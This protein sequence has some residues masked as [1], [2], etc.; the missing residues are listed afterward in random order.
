MALF[1]YLS[2]CCDISRF[3]QRWSELPLIQ[4]FQCLR[5]FLGFRSTYRMLL[6]KHV[7]TIDDFPPSSTFETRPTQD[8]DV[9]TRGHERK[10][11]W[12]PRLKG[13]ERG[14]NDQGWRRGRLPE[15]PC[16][17]SYWYWFKSKF[18]QTF[19]FWLGKMIYN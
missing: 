6:L 13:R 19:Y 5:S 16:L 8:V 11:G 1:W 9:L 4:W 10:L 15:K 12:P 14:F 7:D 2:S 3:K 17:K 18:Q